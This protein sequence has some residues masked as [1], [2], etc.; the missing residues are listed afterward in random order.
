MKPFTWRARLPAA[1]RSWRLQGKL[2]R[3]PRLGAALPAQFFCSERRNVV[4][5]AHGVVV[6]HPLCMRKAL[7][8]NPSVSTFAAARIE[9]ATFSVLG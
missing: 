2:A 3:A 6:S 4:K 5:W 9:L 8:S 1:A 7:G